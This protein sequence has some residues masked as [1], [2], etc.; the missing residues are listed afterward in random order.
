M[1]GQMLEEENSNGGSEAVDSHQLPSVPLPVNEQELGESEDI[2]LDRPE[3]AGEDPIDTKPSEVDAEDPGP[4]NEEDPRPADESSG[5]AE[6]VDS[7]ESSALA[8]NLDSISD[9][10]T[11]LVKKAEKLEELFN[12]KILRS[13]QESQII[14]QMH[15]ELQEYK[16]DLYMKM[17]RPILIDLIELREHILKLSSDL[18]GKPLRVFS[19][20]SY[21]LAQTLENNGVTIY[22]AQIGEL[23]DPRKHKVVEKVFT[24]E[25]GQD[26]TIASLIGEG[27]SYSDRPLSAQKVRVFSFDESAA[28]STSAQP[29]ASQE[30]VEAEVVKEET[31]NSETTVSENEGGIL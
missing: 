20:F 13:Q 30:T 7:G 10:L 11:A 26:K 8:S 16:N 3:E 24:G 6:P 29:S 23:F 12:Q 19:S 5:S 17:I 9:E 25:E 18:E 31:A 22:Q 4:A 14:D 2:P 21:D 27:Y 28:E 1:E 15:A